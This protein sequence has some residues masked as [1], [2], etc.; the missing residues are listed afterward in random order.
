MSHVMPMQSSFAAL[1]DTSV[2]R[3]VVERA[4]RW[5]LPRRICHPLDQFTGK[6]ANADLAAF[7][8]EVDSAPIPESELPDDAQ[9]TVKTLQATADSDLEDDSDL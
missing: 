7:D 1:F 9:V 5:N 6:R 3:A 8:A 2:A 4:A